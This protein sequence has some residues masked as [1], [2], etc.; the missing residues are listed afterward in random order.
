M[1][2]EFLKEAGKYIL[3][4]S[5]IMFAIAFITPLVK[6]MSINIPFTFAMIVVSF[7]GLYLT[8][9]GAKDDD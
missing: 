1:K 9:K 8:Y 6:G 5:K 2:R 3:D 4:L 7:S